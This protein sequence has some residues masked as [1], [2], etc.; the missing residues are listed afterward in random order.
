[1]CWAKN[2][3]RIQEWLYSISSCVDNK[4]KL[5]SVRKVQQGQLIIGVD[6][7]KATQAG[8]NRLIHRYLQYVP[9]TGNYTEILI[10]AST[11]KG[12]HV[13]TV[14]NLNSANHKIQPLIN[15]Y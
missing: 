7:K 11:M 1:M 3:S 5:K 13:S 4:M 2:G 8:I 9:M 12:I 6:D 14:K 15:F 10:Q